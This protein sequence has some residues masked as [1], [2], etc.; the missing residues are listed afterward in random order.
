MET[1]ESAKDENVT[2]RDYLSDY[3][4][5][6]LYIFGMAFKPSEPYMT[7]FMES[8]CE[9]TKDQ[10]NN[11]VFPVYTYM[12]LII[13]VVLSFFAILSMYIPGFGKVQN[14]KVIIV[15]GSLGR[16][17]TRLLLLFGKGLF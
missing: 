10:I 3:L 11:E 4:K 13:L 14:D 9:V 7:Q 2:W 5:C 12:A 1:D 6:L 8:D 17:T 15:F 16:L